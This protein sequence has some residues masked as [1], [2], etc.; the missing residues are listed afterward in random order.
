[1]IRF[2]VLRI[3]LP[4]LLFLILRYIFKTLSAGMKSKSTP[5]VQTGGELKKDPVCGAYVSSA[6][7][8][9]RNVG[10]NTLHFC[11]PE[12]RDKYRAAS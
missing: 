5:P 12:C 3:L 4:L 10:G 6:A 1:M 11:S 7:S 2:F 8:L 9:T